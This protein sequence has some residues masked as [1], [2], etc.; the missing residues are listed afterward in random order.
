MP[1]PPSFENSGLLQILVLEAHTTN[2]LRTNPPQ[3]V[4]YSFKFYSLFNSVHCN[5]ARVM[6]QFPNT[7]T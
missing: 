6:G 2:H 1:L 4:F 3:V 7:L 5:L